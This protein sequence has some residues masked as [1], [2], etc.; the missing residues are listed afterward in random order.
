MVAPLRLSQHKMVL[1]LQLI[2]EIKIGNAVHKLS[3]TVNPENGDY[4]ITADPA[5]PANRVVAVEGY[6]DYERMR[7]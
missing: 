7:V 6:V 3:G 4:N 1:A 2:G 5:I